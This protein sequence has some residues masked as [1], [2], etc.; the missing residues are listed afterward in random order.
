MD[1]LPLFLHLDDQPCVVV[2]GGAIAARKVEALARVG[3]RITVVAPRTAPAIKQLAAAGDLRIELREFVEED[4]RGVLLAI[5]ATG[6]RAVNRR[7][8]EACRARGVLVNTVDDP[9]LCT[10]TF[11]AIVD[12]GPVTVAISTGGSAPALAR[13]LREKIERLLPA[14]TER[15]ARFLS[16]RRADINLAASDGQARR[17]LWDRILDSPV[18]GLAESG[19]EQAAEEALGQ[20]VEGPAETAG[21]VSLVGAG[22]GDP[23]LLTIKALRALQRADIVYYDNLVSAD[24]LDRCRRDAE[25]VYV[26]KR[27]RLAGAGGAGSRGTRQ[28]EINELLLAGA[29][30]GLRVVRLKGGDPFVFG[31]GGEEIETLRDRGVA[32]EVVPGITAALGCAAYAGIPLTHRDWAQSVRFV[33]G[34][35][36]GGEVNLDWPELAR[37]GQTLVVY[38]GLAGL[39]QLTERLI[40]HGMAPETPAATISRGTLPDQAVV[41][42]DLSTLA[43]SVARAGLP[44]PTTTIV[45]RV[46]ALRDRFGPV[47]DSS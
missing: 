16:A 13:Y 44:G 46:V 45:G 10:A 17:R 14:G 12:R 29:R 1:T 33:T 31:R 30:D 36:S 38:M 24:V 3:A 7:V 26:G 23:D 34:H 25:K 47:R 35:V 41:A 39:T 6:D 20:L 42:A 32:F 22:P 37:P 40:E 43:E 27:A 19:Q 5:A 18:P 9:S 15:L 2:G 4:V 21:I 28:A 11:P 8:Y